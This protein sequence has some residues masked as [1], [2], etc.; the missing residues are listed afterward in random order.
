METG[1]TFNVCIVSLMW[2]WEVESWIGKLE[3]GSDVESVEGM[4]FGLGGGQC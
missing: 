3:G 1:I 4:A 2:K